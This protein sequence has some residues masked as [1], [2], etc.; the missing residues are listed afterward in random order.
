MSL[1]QHC[2]SLRLVMPRSSIT[3]ARTHKRLAL[4]TRNGRHVCRRQAQQPQHL[5]DML[6]SSTFIMQN[7][8]VIRSS[9]VL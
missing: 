2:A 6:Y 5:H 8:M 9:C 4:V 1:L 7:C 3:S